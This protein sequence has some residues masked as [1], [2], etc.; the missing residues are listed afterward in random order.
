MNSHRIS[1]YALSALLGG[2]FLVSCQ[3]F[4]NFTTYFNLFYNMERIMDEVEDE[5]LYIREQ[6]TPQPTYYIPYDEQG[7]AGVRI[8]NFLDRRSMTPDETRANKIKLDSILLKGSKLLERSAKSDYVADAEYYIAK[9]YFYEREWY[10]SQKR[11]EE[12]IANFPQSRWYPD[13]H[14]LTAMDMMQQGNLE[15]AEPMISRTIDVAWGRKRRDVLTDAFRLNADFYLGTGD[16]DKALKPYQRALLLSSD[17]EE[18]ARWQ[19]E[20]GVVYFRSADFKQALKEFDRVDEYSPDILTQF[21]TGLQRAVTLRTLGRYDEAQDQIAELHDNGNFEPW[22]GMLELETSNLAADMPG[23]AEIQDSTIQR[24]DSISQGKNFATY[25]IYERAIRAFRAGDYRTAHTNFVKVQSVQAPF[26]RRAQHYAS[27]LGEYI[28]QKDRIAELL[29]VRL[30]EYPDSI[31]TKVSDAYYNIARVFASLDKPDSL[32]YYYDKASEWAPNG[33]VEWER[34]LYARSVLA[35]EGGRSAASDS[36]LMLIAQNNSLTEYAD[37]AR[38]RLNFTEEARQ[39][40]ARDYYMSGIA[41]MKNAGNYPYAITQF[42]HV[43]D[44]YPESEYAPRAYYAIGLMYEQNLDDRDSAFAYYSR[45]LDLYPKSEQAGAVQPMVE[46]VIASR[47]RGQGSADSGKRDD[48]LVPL[49]QNLIPKT[50]SP[51]Q[52]RVDPSQAPKVDKPLDAPNGSTTQPAVDPR[53]LPTVPPNA[54][55]ARGNIS[56]TII[57]PP[58]VPADTAKPESSVPRRRR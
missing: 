42:R 29:R 25:G 33:S 40:P 50:N 6:K 46:A 35:R 44:D 28:G 47:I 27:I 2:L 5:L 16:L 13:A 23:G 45:I 30:S 34:A 10:L 4:R 56:P 18:R 57:N 55:S 51:D 49:D 38:R 17:A 7:L 31:R 52:F 48:G 12:L 14:L 53:S 43:I 19:Y 11:A 41:N 8:F 32:T 1:R 58:V 21:Q 37:E 3:P 39:D 26:Q 24:I 54:A 22:Y 9:T 15:G 20:I 36:L